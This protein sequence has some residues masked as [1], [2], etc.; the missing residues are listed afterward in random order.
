MG[1]PS[2]KKEKQILLDFPTV[3]L[4]AISFFPPPCFGYLPLQMVIN[5]ARRCG[6]RD[7]SQSLLGI[8]SA[9]RFGWLGKRLKPL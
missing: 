6:G 4:V 9:K 3:N 1:G 7:K 8:S 2:I 5:S